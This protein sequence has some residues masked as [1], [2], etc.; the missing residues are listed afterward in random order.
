M[1]EFHEKKNENLPKASQLLGSSI[2][3]NPL[4]LSRD[5]PIFPVNYR[6]EHLR[7]HGFYIRG[8]WIP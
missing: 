4:C 8:T 1:I 5:G 2:L 6:S 7:I 3:P